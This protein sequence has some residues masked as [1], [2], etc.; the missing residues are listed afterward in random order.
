MKERKGK[1]KER[2]KKKK[3]E[4]EERTMHVLLFV[5][6]KQWKETARLKA[7]A[8]QSWCCNRYLVQIGVYTQKSEAEFTARV[9]KKNKK[10]IKKQ[11][12]TKAHKERL[13]IKQCKTRCTFSRNVLFVKL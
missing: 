9:L 4:K 13:L 11:Q 1:K 10:K 3:K 5:A 7:K 12:N 8:C 6:E 2:K